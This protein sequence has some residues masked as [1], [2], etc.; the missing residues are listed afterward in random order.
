MDRNRLSGATPSGASH[1][2]ASAFAV[3]TA[4]TA[5]LVLG[6]FFLRGLFPEE[7]TA[8]EETVLTPRPGSQRGVAQLPRGDV[9]LLDFLQQ[10]A[11]ASGERIAVPG[12]ERPDAAI[13]LTRALGD[14]DL[15][16]ARDVLARNGLEIQAAEVGGKTLYRVK[17]GLARP[18]TKGRIILPGQEG[19]TAED[20]VTPDPRRRAEVR[21]AAPGLYALEEGDGGRYLVII[22]TDS[23]KDAEDI[24]ALLRA[25][26]SLK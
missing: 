10:L 3:V 26:R 9:L 14:L 4:T 16:T 12:G 2:G 21:S 7:P 1:S 20:D 13:V 24:L 8:P 6:A 5:S 17:R 19:A 18:G 23:R 22:E 11:D 15:K 25:R